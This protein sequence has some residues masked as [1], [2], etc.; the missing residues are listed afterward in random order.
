MGW[1]VLVIY[2]LVLFVKLSI[3]KLD[4]S[5]KSYNYFVDS[6]IWPIRLLQKFSDWVFVFYHKTYR[7]W[8]IRRRIK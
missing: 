3:R 6:L 1:V 8:M 5:R 2:I 4:G 7:P